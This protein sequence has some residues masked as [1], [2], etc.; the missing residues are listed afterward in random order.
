MIFR[1]PRFGELIERQLDLFER[2]HGD[3]VLE[4]AERLAAYNRAGREDAEELYGDYLL[5]VE[6]GVE[7]LEDLRDTYARTLAEGVDVRYE[8]RFNRAAA[9][10]L[11]AFP[12]K[13]LEF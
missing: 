13:T 12:L 2:E 1:G 7:A 8:Q 9:R 3:L 4:A 11:P 10:R 6:A 5:T